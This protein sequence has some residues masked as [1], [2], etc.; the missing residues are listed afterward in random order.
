M[1]VTPRGLVI[2][3]PRD[4]SFALMARLYPKVDAFAVL[5]RAQGI[6]KTHGAAGFI[7][8][9]ICFSL[10]LSPMQIGVWTV[11]VTLAFY[12][13]KLFGIFLIPGQVTIPT[14]YSRFTGFGLISIIIIVVGMWRVGLVG[15]LAF[16]VA[17]LA[18]E[19]LTILIDNK[20]GSGIGIKMGEKPLLA[21][22]GA[23]YFALATDFK[24]AYKLYAIKFGVPLNKEVSKEEL[25]KENWAHVWDD[26]V[27]KWPQVTQRFPKEE[28]N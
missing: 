1:I 14:I 15:L 20:M 13:M 24:N 3:L 11:S 23:M 17:R 16:I 2:Y 6:C 5:E 21:K 12:L 27:K 4:Y 28:E 10:G 19:A 7:T 26:L 18:V 9:L 22:A 25:R 8:G